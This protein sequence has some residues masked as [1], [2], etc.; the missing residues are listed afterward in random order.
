MKT[1]DI[2]SMARALQ[3]VRNST[4]EHSADLDEAI[5]VRHDRYE[6][7]HGKK[8]RDTGNNSTWMF[9]HKN[10][11]NVDHNNDK[12]VHTVHNA[13]FGD[14]KKSAKAWAKKHG[15]HAVYV[16]EDVGQ[17]DELSKKT[18]GSYIKK[19]VDDIGDIQRD[20]T[21]DGTRSPTYKS[22]AKKH[23]NRKA[24]VAT[25][26]SKLTKEDVDHTLE[27]EIESIDW[28]IYVRIIEN[29]AAHYKKAAAGDPSDLGQSPGGK[30]M[31]ADLEKGATYDDTEEKGHADAL[32]AARATNK[33]PGRSN[34]NKAGDKSIIKPV[35][36]ITK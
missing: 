28:P 29:R 34:D 16:M 23:K 11:G 26:V 19:S 18:L 33:A 31:K 30:K 25:A 2:R 12:E 4:N 15:H 9:T 3:A 22:L 8:A 27:E 6:R 21:T 13:K 7:S 24:G 14:A 17:I 35:H 1:E 32:K 20:I 36:N 5:E 10:M